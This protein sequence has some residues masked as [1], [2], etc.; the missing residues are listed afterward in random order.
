MRIAFIVHLF[1]N[2]SETFILNQIT[3]LI[4]LGHE[5]DIFADSNLHQNKVHREVEEYQLLRRTHYFHKSGKRLTRVG[6]AILLLMKNF[7]KNPWAILRSFM[8]AKHFK[9]PPLGAWQYVIPF[10]ASNYDIIHCHFGPNGF[11]GALLKESG[12]P[13]KVVVS[14]H[15]SDLTKF[16]VGNPRMYDCLFETCDLLMPVS[17]RFMAKLI[18]LGCAESKVVVHHMGVDLVKYPVRKKHDSNGHNINLITI[19]R[20]TEKK[21][22]KYSLQAIARLVPKYPNILYRIAGDGPLRYELE[23]LVRELGLEKEV[24]LL[25]AIKHDEVKDLM[26]ASHIFVLS[27][28]TAKNGDEEGIP[29]VLMEAQAL[30]MPVLSTIH[31]GIPELVADGVSGYLVPERDVDTLAEKLDCLIEHQELWSEMGQAG[32]QFVE[33]HF[34]IQILNKRLV[35]IYQGLLANK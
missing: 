1:P 17:N 2:L 23:A 9:L 15:G 6:R 5:V 18:T 13:G 26:M 8:I 31:A 25:G 11:I 30:G 21:G 20:L 7:Y 10:L 34:N 12:V 32:R 33:E 29:V 24:M 16:I 3:G 27:S 28:I 14:F 19:A 4:D 35:T 22:V